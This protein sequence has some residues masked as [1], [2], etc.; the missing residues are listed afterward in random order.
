MPDRSAASTRRRRT[1]PPAPHTDQ[2][3]ALIG[4]LLENSRVMHQLL[5]GEARSFDYHAVKDR[6]LRIARS[7]TSSTSRRYRDVARRGLTPPDGRRASTP[8]DNTVDPAR[9]RRAR[10]EPHPD[11][12]MADDEPP[13]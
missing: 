7:S 1:A 6:L 11:P 3:D 12:C 4:M 2:L 5:G 8:R 10:H 9:P 13:Y